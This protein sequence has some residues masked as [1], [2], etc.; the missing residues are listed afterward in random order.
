MSG[1]LEPEYALRRAM[2]SEETYE[3]LTKYHKH[4]I[5]GLTY[6]EESTQ[7]FS[8]EAKCQQRI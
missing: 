7:F 2:S 4:K 3:Q 8:K 6:G 5:N 1:R